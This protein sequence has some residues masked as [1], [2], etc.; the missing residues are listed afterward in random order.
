MVNSRKLELFLPT[1]KLEEEVVMQSAEFI[2]HRED[3]VLDCLKLLLGQKTFDI[4]ALWL[5]TSMGSAY[6]DQTFRFLLSCFHRHG[7]V[8]SARGLTNLPPEVALFNERLALFVDVK[9]F[10]AL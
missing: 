1:V 10:L 5:G 7:V 8:G 3:Q 2:H 6:F 9:R 4:G